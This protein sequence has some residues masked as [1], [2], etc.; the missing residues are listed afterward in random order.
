MLRDNNTSFIERMCKLIEITQELRT[1]RKLAYSNN[2]YCHHARLLVKI[3]II[4]ASV[5]LDKQ[6]DSNLKI[7]KNST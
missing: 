7:G 6:E 1:S 4:V 3:L 2:Y 5:T